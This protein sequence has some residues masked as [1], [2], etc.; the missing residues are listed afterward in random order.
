MFPSLAHWTVDDVAPARDTESLDKH[1]LTVNKEHERIGISIENHPVL[2]ISDGLCQ[3]KRHSAAINRRLQ[4][5][6]I[7]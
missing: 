4:G 1:L 5:Y 2:M 6:G 3:V 7:T